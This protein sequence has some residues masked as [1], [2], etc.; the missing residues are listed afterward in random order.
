V[1][2]ITI[3]LLTLFSV[4]SAF[5]QTLVKEGDDCFDSGNYDCA[6][7]KY[8]DAMSVSSGQNKNI[9][10]LKLGRANRCS[11][12]NK[13]ANQ[14][15]NN[16]N[17]SQAKQNYQNV[18]EG[19]PK[20]EYAQKQIE[21]CDIELNRPPLRKA[22]TAELTDIWNNKY[23]IMPARRQNL[24][25][26]GIDPDDAQKRINAGEGKPTSQP[27][28]ASKPTTT[29]T[30]PSN[31]QTSAIKR[32]TETKPTTLTV[33]K[34]SIYFSS[35]GG[36]SEQIQ[37]YSNADRYSIAVVPNWC[38]VQAN[39]GYIVVTCNTNQSSTHR[40]DYFTIIAGD[41]SKRIY[42][43]QGGKNTCFNCPKNHEKLG[44]T[45]GYIQRE[46]FYDNMDGI[47]V[48][49][50]FEPLFKYG[51]GLN[52]GLNYEY[53]SN[54]FSDY[55]YDDYYEYTYQ[56]HVLNIPLHLEYHLNFSK[57]FNLFAYGGAALDIAT[58]SDFGKYTF[59]TSLEY[60]CG[61]L[62][63]HVQFTLG[64]SYLIGE[65]YDY[66]QQFSDIKY[67]KYKNLALTMSYMF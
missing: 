26:V 21:R 47:L 27:T 24:I 9:A 38:T 11:K 54:S 39:N 8:R 58:D 65:D 1:K 60:G 3:L 45:V 2:H 66:V 37:I 15:F 12:Y 14:A 50:R 18:L 31:T 16:K 13:A 52:I 7:A 36:E 61:L 49:L 29:T 34:E 17:Y 62:I 22:T 32:V 20:D 46:L 63:N 55:S 67:N 53:Y 57:Y 41:K 6:I 48:G 25:N 35:K 59:R 56:E 10:E 42:V 5:C 33:S 4:T 44:V 28:T 64:R 40:Q 51:F 19:N 23:G 30:T 43:T